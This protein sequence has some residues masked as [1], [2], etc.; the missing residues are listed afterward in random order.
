MASLL[1]VKRSNTD[2]DGSGLSVASGELAYS[3]RAVTCVAAMA[4][5][6][7]LTGGSLWIGDNNGDRR[8]VGGDAF[9]RLL[10]HAA[11][12][13]TASLIFGGRNPPISG[14]FTIAEQFNGSAWSTSPALATGR[15]QGSGSGTQASGIHA[16]GTVPSPGQSNATEEFTGETSAETGSAIDFD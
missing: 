7:N 3:T 2:T 13:T 1:Q 16:G 6:T 11:G 5:S 8:L 9:T 12:T 15:F 10:T 4:A 14:N